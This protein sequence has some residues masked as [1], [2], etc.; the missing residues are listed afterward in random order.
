MNATGESSG[1]EGSLFR[2]LAISLSR[3]AGAG[4]VGRTGAADGGVIGFGVWGRG[5]TGVGETGTESG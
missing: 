2:R 4:A 5:A 1:E 3:V